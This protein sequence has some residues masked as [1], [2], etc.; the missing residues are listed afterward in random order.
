[1][2]K[3]FIYKAAVCGVLVTLLAL[4][5][6]QEVAAQRTVSGQRMVSANFMKTF[7]P[8]GSGKVMG[9]DAY[10]GQY[11]GTFYW[12]AGAQ[13]TG[14]KGVPV[15]CFNLSAGAMYRLFG[16]RNRMFNGYVGGNALVGVDFASGSKAVSDVIQSDD[17]GGVSVDDIDKSEEKV[18]ETGFVYG[19]EP[20]VELEFFPFRAF[21][22]VGGVALPVKFKTQQDVV[23]GRLYVGLRLNF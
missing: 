15:M 2:K 21:A 1:M 3:C 12:Q 19:L 13:F 23:S 11:L 14:G 22:L 6:S 20:R 4:M 8:S 7:S 17:L 5:G 10:F 16:T 18:Y 9:A